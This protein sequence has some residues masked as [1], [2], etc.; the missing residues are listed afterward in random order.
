MNRILIVDDE[1]M[2][3]HIVE[4]YLKREGFK[5]YIARDGEEALRGST[6]ETFERS[7]DS[8]IKRLRQKIEPNPN[9]PRFVSTVFGVGYKFASGDHN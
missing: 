5:T 3:I 1:K 8:H 9:S 7:I 2:I 4:A 6:Y